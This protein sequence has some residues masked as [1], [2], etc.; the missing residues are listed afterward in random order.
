MVQPVTAMELKQ[1]SKIRPVFVKVLIWVLLAGLVAELGARLFVD[2][3]YQGPLPEGIRS[4][5]S[6]PTGVTYPRSTYRLNTNGFRD[7]EEVDFDKQQH[8]LFL[9]DS[10][11]FGLG[12][13]F[14]DT[15]PEVVETLAQKDGLDVQSINAAAMGHDTIYEYE[16]LENVLEG[17]DIRPEFVIL[18][19]SHNDLKGNQ[20]HY[21]ETMLKEQNKQTWEMRWLAFRSTLQRFFQHSMVYRLGSAGY[22]YALTGEFALPPGREVRL[23]ELAAKGSLEEIAASAEW[24]LTRDYIDRI[25]RLAQE[26]N[27]TLIMIYVPGGDIELEDR[28]SGFDS[29]LKDYSE[30]AGII[31]VSGMDVYVRYLKNEGLYTGESFVL[32]EGFSNIPGEMGHPGP[33]A[34]QLLAQALYDTIKDYQGIDSN[35]E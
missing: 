26:H 9:G 16:R 17:T 33:L 11:T 10:L 4:A 30:E 18:A 29:L 24:E 6:T 5:G 35:D 31:Y 7:D 2:H 32:P 12:L 28:P 8:W 21:Y 13:E 19:V 27:S 1:R 25:H 15:Y 3:L 22:Y 14:A 34:T 20:F 23:T